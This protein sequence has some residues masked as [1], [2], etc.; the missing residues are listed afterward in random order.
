MSE[1]PPVRT[2]DDEARSLARRLIGGARHGALGLIEP[3]T[4][5]PFVTRISVVP[6]PDGVPLALVSELAL[7][8][9]AL[10]ADPRA[11]LLLGEPGGRGDP[12]THPRLTLAVRASFLDRETALR[13]HYLALQP[14]ARLYIDFADFH[15]VRLAPEAGHLNGGFGRAWRLAAADLATG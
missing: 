7:H 14:K 6:G 8:T 4:G 2:V 11:S 13:D 15:L 1:T 9:R 5:A 12:L 3:D 10:R